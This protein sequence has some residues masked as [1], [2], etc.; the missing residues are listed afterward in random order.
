MKTVEINRKLSRV[1]VNGYVEAN[2]VLK[3][4]NKTGKR[5]ELWPFV[6]YNVVQF[7]HV[8]Q[9]YDKKA[10]P[11]F[12]RNLQAAAPLPINAAEEAITNLFSEDN[13]NACSI[14]WIIH[15]K[16]TYLGYLH[17][18]IYS[19]CVFFSCTHTYIYI[20]EIDDEWE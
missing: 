13:P 4:V 15:Q 9:V 5:A 17:F 11:G 6:P 1:T 3:R 20:T 2:K 16:P 10:P 7:P 18:H 14:M 12:V 19:Y 8:S